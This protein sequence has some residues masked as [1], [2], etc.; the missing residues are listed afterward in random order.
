MNL[1]K[2][3]DLDTLR[4][5]IDAIPSNI[6]LKDPELN[7][8]FSSHYW[9]QI[10]HSAE[11]FDIYGKSD[12]DV[13]KDT[14]NLENVDKTDHEILATGEGRQYTIKAEV[15]G[16]TQY[17]NIVKAPVRDNDGNIIGIVGLINDVSTAMD[18]VS[19]KLREAAEE[20]E[21][22]ANMK[23][24]FLAN[25]SHEIRTPMNAII[26][27]TEMAL[28]ENLPPAAKEYISQIKSSGNALLN[29]INDI[30]DFSKIESEKMDIIP[31]EY[32]ILSAMHDLT[33]VFMTRLQDKDV[34]LI[35]TVNP[36]TPKVLYGDILRIKQIVINIGNNAIKFTKHG[37]VWIDVDFEEKSADEV[38]FIIS[39]RDT[40]IGIKEEDLGK[41][42][43]AFQQVDAKRNRNIEGTG[44]GLA[45]TSRLLE[46]MGGSISVSSVYNEGSCF[47][48]R[49][50]QKVVDREPVLFVK[51]RDKKAVIGYWP[52][53]EGSKIFYDIL[54]G[55]R[56]DSY[57]LIS[58]DRMERLR[59]IY[60]DELKGREI[61]LFTTFTH[62]NE[63][64]K[65]FVADNPDINFIVVCEFFTKVPKNETNV[66]FIKKPYS[67]IGIVSALNNVEAF[68]NDEH[69]FEF[70]FV[71]PDAKVLFVDDNEVN[72]VVSEGLVE[73]L[74]M[75]V[76]T[77]Q[78]GTEAIELLQKERFDLVFMDHMM[79]ELDGVQ[80][81]RIIRK[82]HPELRDMPI[83]ALT[84]NAVGEVKK[85]F[86]N[87]GMNDFVAKPIEVQKLIAAIHQWLPKEK[88]VKKSEIGDVNDEIVPGAAGDTSAKLEIGDIDVDTAISLIGNEKLYMTVLEK[89]YNSIRTKAEVIRRYEQTEDIKAYTIEVH[90]LKSSS[91]QIG[92]MK[93]SAMA[94]QAEQCGN[95]GDIKTIH[96]K[97]Q[98]LL[99]KYLSYEDVLSP[100]FKK[101]DVTSA[102][103]ESIPE[104]VLK[105]M[106][107]RMS[108][109][110][111]NLDMDEME[112]VVNEM[113]KYSFGEKEELF[114]ALKNAVSYI[115]VD[116]I[117]E[118]I[119]EW[120]IN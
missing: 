17:L 117:E 34:E 55:L 87:E 7:Y 43:D 107:N 82:L 2:H 54:K 116:T 26:G 112:A 70:E 21:R 53:D 103:K 58:L 88:L 33:S 86:L 16:R 104:D 24:D 6:F 27:M 72:L 65:E 73:P 119:S 48:I 111:D 44:L 96:E 30:L 18:E 76:K 10:D 79:P 61:Y 23:S 46:L 60:E 115:D 52:G 120:G 3:V 63:K 36:N 71:A 31:E 108:E 37:Y 4:N 59:S 101:E 9:D 105:A 75:Q 32:N 45:I 8:I 57:A 114:A 19:S 66:K 11:D 12:W 113:D 95:N 98:L 22:A 97:T 90:A 51:D 81:T 47:T 68:V 20:A 15:D 74:K 62:Y 42:F 89:Y 56:I 13:R 94:A 118:I 25:M 1:V 50:P 80:T 29:I 14:T 83:I 41:L 38:E 110:S 40:G 69:Q 100:I 99:E 106:L 92:A 67:T 102:V 91:K 49:I 77:A 78:S 85:M 64:M 109:A 84:A 5:V 39:V 93:L 35:G 28:R